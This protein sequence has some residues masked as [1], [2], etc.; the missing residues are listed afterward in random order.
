MFA[1]NGMHMFLPHAGKRAK[2]VAMG[3]ALVQRTAV[4]N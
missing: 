1:I 4:F 3:M 2:E